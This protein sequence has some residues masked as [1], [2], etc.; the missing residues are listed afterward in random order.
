MSDAGLSGSV[1]ALG[2]Y[3]GQAYYSMQELQDLIMRSHGDRVPWH[4]WVPPQVVD[5]EP[6]VETR[7][8]AIADLLYDRFE[9][10]QPLSARLYMPLR[11]PNHWPLEDFAPPPRL[12]GQQPC[13]GYRLRKKFSNLCRQPVSTPSV[14]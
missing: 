13:K 8:T 9:I 12:Q 6:P 5:W 7:R 1:E 14:L 3:R 4:V 10:G 11:N 2:E